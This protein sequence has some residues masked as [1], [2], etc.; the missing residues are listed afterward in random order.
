MENNII[1]HPRGM[2]IISGGNPLE[3]C[4]KDWEE[5]KSIIEKMN[6][7]KT[8]NEPQW[9]FDCGFKLDYDGGLVNISS[10]FYPPKT[11]YGPTWD[12]V[13]HVYLLGKLVEDKE[14]DCPTLNELKRQVDEYI[15]NIIGK[16]QSVFKMMNYS[17]PK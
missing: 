4:P 8:G 6:D 10:R 17:L 9:S 16:M 1:E 14:F 15:S 2:I 12:G 11:H 3:G 5:A 13:V 7:G